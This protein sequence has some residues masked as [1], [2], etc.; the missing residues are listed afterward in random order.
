MNRIY[1]FLNLRRFGFIV[2]FAVLFVSI[3]LSDPDYFW[4]LSAGQYIWENKALPSADIFSYTFAGKPWVLHEWLFEIILFGIYSLT[5]GLGVKLFTAAFATATVLVVYA[6]S[7]R[8]LG[9]PYW[10]FFLAVIFFNQIVP[11]ISP[12]PQLITFLLFAIYWRVLVDF[13][14]FNDVGKLWLLPVLMVLWVNSHGGYVAGLVLIL[15][16]LACEWLMFILQQQGDVMLKQRLKKL[17]IIAMVTIAATLLN[18]YFIDHWIYPF[19]VMNMDAAQNIITEWR[20]PDFHSFRWKFFL[21]LVFGALTAPIYSNKRP[22]FTELVL[23]VFFI[24]AAFISIRHAPI[25]AL[26]I[27]FFASVTLGH[28]TFAKIFSFVKFE[29][30]AIQYR[31]FVGKGNDLG[32]TEFLFNWILLAITLSGCLLYYPAFHAKV[33]DKINKTVPVKAVQFI[34]EAEIQ[35]RGFAVYHYG[36]YLI[37]QFYPE[38]LVFIDGRGDMYGDKF[39]QE[40]LAIVEA[41]AGWKDKMEKYEIDYAILTRK[42]ALV[43]L[44]QASADF[45]LIHEDEVNAVLLK[46]DVKYASI[47]AKYAKNEAN[48]LQ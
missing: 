36:G 45:K 19:S 5:G 15:L 10:A 3:V 27:V 8:L 14:Y 47:I 41:R 4:H 48:K 46:N 6:L 40:Y 33:E 12:R 25:S 30:L 43:E 13:K 18:P 44:L 22:D 20:S 23:S 7:K 42:S 26:A 39:I 2:I 1:E 34:K 28:V 24:T 11:N 16:F 32:K 31:R 17:S 29:Q 38:Q 35:G 9:K 21:L 37:N